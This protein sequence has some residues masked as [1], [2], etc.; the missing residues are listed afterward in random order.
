MSNPTEYNI[1]VDHEDG[2]CNVI[3]G[4]LNPYLTFDKLVYYKYDNKKNWY[5][6]HIIDMSDVKSVQ[7]CKIS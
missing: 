2:V 7:V 5:D 4:A 3:F 6:Q 1:T